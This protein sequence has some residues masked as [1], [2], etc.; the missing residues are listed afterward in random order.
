M[1]KNLQTLKGFRDFLPE[2]K[3]QRDFVEQKI[4][5]VFKLF[6]FEPVET[7]TLE[8]ASLLLGKYGDEADKLVYTFK[9]RGDR[10]VGLRYDQTVPTARVLAENQKR[11]TELPKLLRRYQI[12]NVF[13]ADKP[14]AGRYREFKQCD[15]DIFGVEAKALTSEA[16]LIACISNSL[17]NLGFKE[18]RL[19]LNNRLL[20][21]DLLTVI[22]EQQSFQK[23][24]EQTLARYADRLDKST[25][26][27]IF[28]QIFND[29]DLKPILGNAGKKILFEFLKMKA[30]RPTTENY[31][32]L[33]DFFLYSPKWLKD[34]KSIVDLSCDLGVDKNKLWIKPNLARGLDYY[35]GTII[36]VVIPQI[37][38]GS[39]GGGGRYDG[40]IKK[41]SNVNICAVGFSFGF[42][43]LIEAMK[44]LN[45][46]PKE[47]SLPTTKVLV[48]IFNQENLKCSAQAAACLR[49]A[50]INTEVYPDPD[51]RLNKQLKYASQKNIPWVVVIGPEEVEQKKIALKNMKT[52]KQKVLDIKKAIEIL[53]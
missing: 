45:L 17:D 29:K 47:L 33:A 19:L 30:L 10:L 26:D 13:R 28:Q 6:G 34:L 15:I 38:I 2:E 25:P 52:G 31:Q 37:D 7:P 23:P 49:K 27:I 14:Q 11:P 4:K 51:E 36:E 43:R 5:E 20:F 32:K 8:Y 53:I 21:R 24:L 12:Q 9:D 40:L 39:V 22:Q 50:N 41:L 16:E 3:R 42:D 35:T 44:I 48:T 46:F 18:Y 1:K